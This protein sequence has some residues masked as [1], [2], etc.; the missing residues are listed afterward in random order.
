L[1]CSATLEFRSA[2]F[3]VT[4][5]EEQETTTGIS[6]MALAEWV[7]A[8]LLAR[9]YRPSEVIPKDVGWCVPVAASPH[10]LY[11]TCAGTDDQNDGWRIFVHTEGGFITRLF[12][13]DRRRAEVDTL[14]NALKQALQA[15]PD[16][17]EIREVST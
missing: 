15:A 8:Q 4:L 12:R 2:A 10:T 13:K 17:Q 3:P 5:E 11:V 9:G 14:F 1:I 7:S 6:G 16:V